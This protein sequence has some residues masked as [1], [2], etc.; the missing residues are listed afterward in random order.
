MNRDW[1][2][3][4]FYKTLGVSESATDKEITKAYRKLARDL[5]PD[6]NPG[7]L[8]ATQRFQ[9]LAIACEPL[10]ATESGLLAAIASAVY[11]FPLEHT[12]HSTL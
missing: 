2:D 9:N 10:Y 7:D 6:K 1:F 12:L 11:P 8:Y 5:H 3:K 4:D